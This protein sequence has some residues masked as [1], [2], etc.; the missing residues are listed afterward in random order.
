MIF[1]FPEPRPNFAVVTAELLYVF[2]ETCGYVMSQYYGV[3]FR[4]II[5]LLVDE[6]IA[7]IE[8]VRIE[9]YISDGFVNV[10]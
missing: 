4:K 5:Q 10:V 7:K 1:K 6:Y 2:L 9:K 8:K 3:Q